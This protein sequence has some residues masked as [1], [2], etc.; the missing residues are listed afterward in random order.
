VDFDAMIC[1][2]TSSTILKW[3]RLKGVGD[4]IFSLSQQWIG[5][6]YWVIIGIV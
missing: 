5:I 4:M 6:D 1:N 3:L 2:P